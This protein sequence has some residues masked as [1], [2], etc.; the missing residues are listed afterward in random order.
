MH[1]K[2]S[3]FVTFEGIEGSGKSYHSKK[4]FKKVKKLKF[5]A[6][7]SREPG[8]SKGAEIIRN[9]VLMGSKNK[10]HKITDAL[11]YLASR[12]E[13]IIDTLKPAIKKKK[14]I[15]CDRFIDSTEAYQINGKGISR[16]LVKNVHKEIL[17]NIKPDLTFVLKVNISKALQRLRKRKKKN[18]YDKFSKNFYSKAQSAF[19]KIAKKDKKRCFILDN[20]TDSSKVEK[21][22]LDRFVKALNK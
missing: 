15:I 18:R 4:L 7:Y 6:I 16:S 11:L 21:I 3:F 14:V 12:N 17:N 20:S 10:F 19:I 22:I 5:P 2:K 8:G 13:H 1:K 9:L